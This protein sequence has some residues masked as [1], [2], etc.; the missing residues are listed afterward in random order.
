MIGASTGAFGAVWAQAEMRKV[1]AACGARVV[2]GEVALG[3]AYERFDERG[4]LV[5]EEARDQLRDVIGLLVERRPHAPE[6]ARRLSRAQVAGRVGTT[7][8]RSVSSAP[9]PGAADAVTVP[10]CASAAWRT[11]ARPSP[12]PGVRRAAAAR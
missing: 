2:D 6:R 8:S 10:P 5:D 11:I 1:L 4:V 7:G 3:H 12:E 9:P